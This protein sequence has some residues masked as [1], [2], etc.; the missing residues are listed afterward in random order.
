MCGYCT[1]RVHVATCPLA[2]SI[3]SDRGKALGLS[4]G[5]SLWDCWDDW[6]EASLQLDH[7]SLPLRILTLA[8]KLTCKSRPTVSY[9]EITRANIHPDLQKEGI[10]W[11][12]Q[13]CGIILIYW[14]SKWK[15]GPQSSRHSWSVLQEPRADLSARPN[16]ESL[17]RL[18]LSL[19]C[20]LQL[21]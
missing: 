8:P 5:C 6:M 4:D 9:A 3:K 17:M 12:H 11:V 2:Q 15:P 20:V 10:C 21:N 7:G 19:A 1:A 13:L 18:T 14:R 16:G